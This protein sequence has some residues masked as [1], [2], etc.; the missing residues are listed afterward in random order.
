MSLGLI[1]LHICHLMN[2]TSLKLVQ[3]REENM[4]GTSQFKSFLRS[5]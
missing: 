5:K 3:Y 2:N 4:S 1:I